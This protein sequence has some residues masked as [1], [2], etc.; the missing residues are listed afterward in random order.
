MKTK[1]I[2][3]VKDEQ[4]YLEEWINYHL[5]LGFDKIEIYEDFG[6]TSHFGITQKYEKV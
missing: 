2:T 3:L 4:E 1:I 5:Q 6:S